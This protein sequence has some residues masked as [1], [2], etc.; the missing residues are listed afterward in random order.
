MKV[1]IK[2]PREITFAKIDIGGLFYSYHNVYMRI[3]PVDDNGETYDAVNLSNGSLEYVDDK[4]LVHK[5]DGEL[6]VK[7]V[8]EI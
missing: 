1:N 7:I 5:L 3:I 8:T 2:M 6:N 4:R